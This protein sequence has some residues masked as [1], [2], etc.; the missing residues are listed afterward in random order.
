MHTRCYNVALVAII[1]LATCIYTCSKQDDCYKA[2]SLDTFHCIS[3]YLNL[4]YKT[5]LM[6]EVG[7]LCAPSSRHFNPDLIKRSVKVVL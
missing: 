7:V 5:T 2:D 4:H 6:M 3:I 1:L